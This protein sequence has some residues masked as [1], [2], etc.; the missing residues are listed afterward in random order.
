M[1]RKRIAFF[2]CCLLMTIQLGRLPAS[3]TEK[4]DNS[5]VFY[6]HECADSS[7]KIALTFDDGPHPKYTKKILDILEQYGVRA[8]FF[9]IGQNVEYWPDTAKQV[10]Q[11][12]H[13]IGN[14]TYSHGN[15]SKENK[16]ALL[17]DIEKGEGV[18]FKVTGKECLLFR[19]PEGRMDG[20]VKAITTEKGYS[21]ILWSVDTRDWAHTPVDEIARNIRSNVRSGSIILMHDFIAHDSPTPKALEIII[22]WLL[23]QGYEFVTVSELLAE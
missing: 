15:V 17:C 20:N 16:N 9:M 7:M 6:E 23:S 5:N 8:T 4:K 22:P 3:A 11:A 13:E 14:H 19:P 12:G 2:L 10:A 18:I 1:K 21:V